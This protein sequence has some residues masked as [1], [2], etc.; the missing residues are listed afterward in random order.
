MTSAVL[1]ASMMAGCGN[2]KTDS[3]AASQEESA[4]GSGETGDS[5]ESESSADSVVSTDP[6]IMIHEGY[7]SWTYPV[8][9][10][11]DMCA[12]FHFYEEQPV[13][14]SV[15]YAGFAWNQITY[16][17]TYTVEE[18][19][20]AYNVSFT[21]D[22]QTADP[23]VLNEG[24]APYTVT[25]YDFDGNELGSCGYDGE[26]LYNDSPVDGTGAGP[27]R[28]SHDVDTASKYMSTYEAELGIAYLDFVAE[29]EATS[30]LALYHNGR[31]MDLVDM[32]IEGT[33]SMAESAEGYEFTLTPDSAS[34]TGAVIVVAAD[35]NTGVYTADG[36]EAV[37]MVNAKNSG[38][39]AVLEMKGTTPIPGQEVEA[40]VIGKL[41]DDGKVTVAASAFGSEIP[42]DEGIWTMGEDGYTITF[43][44]TVAGE[45][46]S[47]LG[48]AGAVLQYIAA[49]E[50][51]GEIDT[52]LVIGFASDGAAAPAYLLHGEIPVTEEANGEITGTLYDDGT[53]TLAVSAFGQSLDLDVGTYTEE[54]FVFTFQFEVAGELVSTFGD[55]GAVVQ[56]VGTSEVLGEIDTELVISLPE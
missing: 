35:Q 5:Q 8:D 6:M 24:T 50:L 53:V 44:F 13:L 18:K 41:Y 34:D 27:V 11:D 1:C 19:E 25:F 55:A 33:W 56:Y 3:D 43:Q 7:Y 40:D 46:V 52:E 30:T 51:L 48:E 28:Y 23:A 16:V 39:K 29:D 14:G 12:F 32:M 20:C 38:P 42:L 49:S 21:R 15:F 22:D 36:G 2:D 31:Y 4:K 10:M 26:Y 47:G 9:G 54:N 45:L 37:N 17:G